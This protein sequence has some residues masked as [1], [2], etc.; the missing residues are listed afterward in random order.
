MPTTAP[1]ASASV[2]TEVTRKAGVRTSARH[3]WRKSETHCVMTLFDGVQ[4]GE[5]CWARRVRSRGD[6]AEAARRLPSTADRRSGEL[7]S[8]SGRQPDTLHEDC[9]ARVSAQAV[10]HRL[11]LE[12]DQARASFV[13]GAPQPLHRAIVLPETGVDKR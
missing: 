1:M 7:V 2:M 12:K 4:A 9:E 8:R 10:E 6:E 5:V 11:D 13:V 3:P